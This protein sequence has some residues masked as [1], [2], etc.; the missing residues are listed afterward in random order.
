[1]NE[2]ITLWIDESTEIKINNDE[3]NLIGY[4]ITD[5]Y[6]DE[7]NFLADLK[8][9]RNIE[10]KCWTT[11]HGSKITNC[12]DREMIL[13]D[14]WLDI[15]NKNSSVYFHCFF[16]KKNTKYISKSKNYEHY[17]AKQSI[18]SL[19]QKM[20]ID[21]ENINKIFNK[22]K[23]LTILFDRRRAHSANIINKENEKEIERINELEDVYRDEIA[24][25]IKKITGKDCKTKN[26]TIRFSFVS[27]ECFDGMQFTDGLLYLVRKKIEQEVNNKEN[28]FTKLFDKYFLDKYDL[29]TKKLGFKKIYEFSTKFNFFESNSI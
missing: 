2:A 18:F 1:M 23:T 8:K 19:A 13:L 17:F 16:Y 22:T 4:L 6:L 27:S 7:L 9:V 11:I 28:D 3:Y 10:P 29:H 20:K 12:K 21:G 26:F 24:E 5:S 25:Q 15:F 14:R